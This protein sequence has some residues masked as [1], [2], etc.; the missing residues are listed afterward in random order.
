MKDGLVQA[1]KRPKNRFFLRPDPKKRHD[2]V[3]FVGE[4]RPPAGKYAFCR[5]VIRFATDLGVEKVFTF[6]A[7][8]TRMNPKHDA[9][10]FAAATD[11]PNLEE[12]KRLELTVLEEGHIG[13]LNGV[14]LGAAVDAGMHGVC[15]LGEMPHVF[16][17][18]PFPP[19]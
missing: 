4:A 16:A 3:V 5:Q 12:L 9:R 1:G 8:A 2:F 11:L 7:M 13:G 14:L 15:L 6:A 17:R 18:L 19:F 10:V